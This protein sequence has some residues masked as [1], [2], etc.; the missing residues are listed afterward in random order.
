MHPR[1][2][3]SPETCK[4]RRHGCPLAKSCQCQTHSINLHVRGVSDVA[5][6]VIR[7]NTCMDETDE[8]AGRGSE[9]EKPPGADLPSIARGATPGHE[10]DTA[11]AMELRAASRLRADHL[12][13]SRTAFRLRFDRVV[14]CPPLKLAPSRLTL[15]LTWSRCASHS[16]ATKRRGELKHAPRHMCA[17]CG[18]WLKLLRW[19]DSRPQAV[20]STGGQECR[21]VSE[22]VPL[23]C[24]VSGVTVVG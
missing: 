9:A 22:A 20:Y 18:R 7:S 23:P 3:V 8:A 12:G 24:V 11:R 6:T 13:A 10:R 4:F 17:C 1:A 15:G 2:K 16:G 14:A 21:G 19:L 5:R